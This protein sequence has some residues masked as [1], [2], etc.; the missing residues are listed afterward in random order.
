MGTADPGEI[1][2]LG[3]VD[4]I[5]GGF[6][7]SEEVYP[8]ISEVYRAGGDRPLRVMAK[9]FGRLGWEVGRCIAAVH[10]AGFDWGTYQDHSENSILDNT[11]LNNAGFGQRAVPALVPDGL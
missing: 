2:E 11:P 6:V 3:D 4:L 1:N 10:R 5:K 9:L 8:V 7:P